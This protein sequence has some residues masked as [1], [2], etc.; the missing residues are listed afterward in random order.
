MVGFA[1]VTDRTTTP[2]EESAKGLLQQTLLSR[3]T[4]ICLTQLSVL[5]NLF[6]LLEDM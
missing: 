6:L 5:G 1:L 3:L 2:L 4:L